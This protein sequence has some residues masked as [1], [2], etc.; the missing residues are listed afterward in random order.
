MRK[1]LFLSVCS[2][3]LI[4]TSAKASAQNFIDEVPDS[5]ENHSVSADLLQTISDAL[6]EERGRIDQNFLNRAYDPNISLSAESQLAVTFIN[7]GAGYRNSLGYFTFNDDTFDGLT[8]GDIDTDNSS[9]I[10]TSEIAA[11]SGVSTNMVFPNASLSYSGGMLN[12]GDTYV[13]GGGSIDFTEDSWM[14][15][16]GTLFDAGT[17]VGFFLSTNAWNDYG[18]VGTVDGWDGTAGDPNVYYTLDFLNPENDANATIDTLDYTTRHIALTFESE[19]R[20]TL[21]MG[22]EDLYQ[23]G[24]ADFNDAVFLVRSDPTGAMGGTN[25]EVYSAPVPVAGGGFFGF[26]ALMMIGILRR[27]GLCLA[28]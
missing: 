20:N 9:R 14:I 25:V 7:E 21:I 2:A 13:L 6:P 28:T 17:N 10:S 15:N 27:F 26:I 24:D 4:M 18:D 23:L 5:V 11:I 8:F 22:F 12:Q 19:D 16:D 1:I 3:A